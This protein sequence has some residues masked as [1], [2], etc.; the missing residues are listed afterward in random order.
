MEAIDWIGLTGGVAGIITAF[1]AA[2]SARRAAIRADRELEMRELDLARKELRKIRAEH[3]ATL[4]ALDRLRSE[5]DSL[6]TRVADLEAAL[7]WTLMTDLHLGPRSP[8]ARVLDHATDLIAIVDSDG[9]TAWVNASYDDLL[10]WRRD[11]VTGRPWIEIVDPDERPAALEAV[12]VLTSDPIVGART[13]FVS[14]AGARVA[15]RYWATPYIRG[16][17]FVLA[18]PEAAGD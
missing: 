6:R 10:G 13:V 7:P 8:L 15:V 3:A 17:S 12:A 11:A 18:R 16:S 14:R 4:E 9:T 2:L 5:A 1:V